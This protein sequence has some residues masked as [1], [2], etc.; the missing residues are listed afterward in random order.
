MVLRILDLGLD[1]PNLIVYKKLE[2]GR[3]EESIRKFVRFSL[4]KWY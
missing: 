3:Y 4:W 2:P 1:E